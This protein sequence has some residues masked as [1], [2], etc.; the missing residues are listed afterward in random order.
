MKNVRAT[1]AAGKGERIFALASRRPSNRRCVPWCCAVGRW[2]SVHLRKSGVAT[3]MSSKG[4]P[5]VISVT[6]LV[7]TLCT[8]SVIHINQEIIL[9]LRIFI[10]D[11]RNIFFLRR[12]QLQMHIRLC[13]VW[14]YLKK[15]WQYSLGGEE[16]GG[17]ETWIFSARCIKVR[18]CFLQCHLEPEQRLQN[19][20]TG[21]CFSF[22][23]LFIILQK[24]LARKGAFFLRFLTTSSS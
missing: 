16:G 10:A 18:Y 2:H 21:H 20:Y 3:W 11:S 24:V 22:F 15:M 23:P 17:I 13:L 19:S 7:Y 1:K 5:P 8:K 9:S 4:K 12:E 6:T 14:S